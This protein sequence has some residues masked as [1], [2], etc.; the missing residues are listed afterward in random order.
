[1]V[2]SGHDAPNAVEYPIL[3]SED[4]IGDSLAVAA[5]HALELVEYAVVLVQITE[6]A[7]QMVVYRDYFHGLRVHV[8][9]P[10]LHRQIITRQDESAVL[11]EF[12]V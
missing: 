11:A 1:M 5:E 8:Y 7:P 12:H 6:F 9:I 3:L 10:D 2:G 4:S